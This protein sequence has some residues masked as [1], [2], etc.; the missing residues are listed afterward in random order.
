[1]VFGRSIFRVIK[2]DCCEPCGGVAESRVDGRINDDDKEGFWEG[3]VVGQS[4]AIDKLIN[5][6]RN[7]E[8]RGVS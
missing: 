5:D 1:M 6:G 8:Q 7:E 2:G 3:L 4:K